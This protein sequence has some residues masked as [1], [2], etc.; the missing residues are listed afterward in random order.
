MTLRRDEGLYIPLLPSP[1][2]RI[3]S[4]SCICDNTAVTNSACPT[5]AGECLPAAI[6]PHSRWRSQPLSGVSREQRYNTLD[7]PRESRV[8]RKALPSFGNL[9][10]RGTLFPSR[11]PLPTWMLLAPIGWTQSQRGF[12]PL[13]TSPV[14][15]VAIYPALAQWCPHTRTEKTRHENPPRIRVNFRAWFIVYDAVI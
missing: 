3:F 2:S 11:L 8:P 10:P 6:C 5:A 13:D 1:S 14:R 15:A 4:K 7:F 12:A 9:P